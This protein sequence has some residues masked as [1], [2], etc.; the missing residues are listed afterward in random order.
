MREIGYKMNLT[1]KMLVAAQEK[2]RYMGI[3]DEKYKE[4]SERYYDLLAEWQKY[5]GWIK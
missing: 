3:D 5:K 2:A 4:A 1:E